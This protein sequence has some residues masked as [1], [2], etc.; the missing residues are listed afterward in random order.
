M[1]LNRNSL[2]CIM[3]LLDAF[4]QI[5]G[6][7]F[8]PETSLGIR[9]RSY[10]ESKAL[11][12]EAATGWEKTGYGSHKPGGIWSRFP[13]KRHFETIVDL[14][15]G[16]GRHAMYLSADKGVTCDRYYG[17][18]IAEGMLRRLLNCK[19]ELN[20]FATAAHHII[21][22]PLKQLPIADASADLVYSSSVFMHLQE[23]DIQAVLAEIQRILKPGGSFIFNDSF[24]N[25][26][27]SSYKISNTWRKWFTPSFKTMYLRQYTLSEIEALIVNSRIPEKT[28]SYTI[29]PCHYE[30][31]PQ[32]LQ[33]WLPG[34]KFVNDRLIKKA[35]PETKRQVYASA[36]SVYSN[37]LGL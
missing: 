10:A 18:D 4:E 7:Y 34:A 37:N 23:A 3:V 17:L 9:Q 24:H 32:K 30:A 36:Y 29:A 35:D 26:N 28:A 33:R 12:E 13:E 31:L 11:W 22:M 20:F 16:Y 14:G 5:D 21:C 1:A 27:C 8:P 15:C 6:I 25:Q 2:G 19:A